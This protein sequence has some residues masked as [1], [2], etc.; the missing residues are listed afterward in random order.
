MRRT[1]AGDEETRQAMHGE[2]DPDWRM[3]TQVSKK[4]DN[5]GMGS[6]YSVERECVRCVTSLNRTGILTYLPVSSIGV[7]GT[8]RKEDPVPTRDLVS[9]L[10]SHNGE[11]VRRKVH[12]G[13]D[14]LEKIS[15]GLYD[16][17]IN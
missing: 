16:I 13:F 5:T 3:T 11:L 14:R 6:S 9:A 1:F 7:P 8:M 4:G 10:F 12:Q 15:S 17:H 2:I